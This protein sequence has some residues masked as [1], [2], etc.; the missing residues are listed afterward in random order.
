[1]ITPQ[2]LGRSDERDL[3]FEHPLRKWVRPS[4]MHVAGKERL[5]R[6]A[7]VVEP[8]GLRGSAEADPLEV[9]K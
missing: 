8:K 3:I 7:L 4:W 9:R 5:D 2:E 6:A 1:V